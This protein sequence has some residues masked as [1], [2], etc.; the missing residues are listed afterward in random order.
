MDPR[1]ITSTT[2]VT[3]DRTLDAR[4]SPPS[5]PSERCGKPE[6]KA[7]RKQRL[8]EKACTDPDG[9]D[10]EAIGSMD[11]NELLATAINSAGFLC[12][13]V[14]SMYPRGGEVIAKSAEHRSGKD[15]VTYRVNP[16]A[17]SIEQID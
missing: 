6:T 9:A 16:Q 14:T 11:R 15:R 13:R 10:A 17:G 1:D 7:E 4:V 12:A 5:L 3:E 2:L 8:R